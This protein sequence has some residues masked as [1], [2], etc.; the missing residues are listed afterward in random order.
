MAKDNKKA[1]E[2][3]EKKE[4]KTAQ[5][6]NPVI[7]ETN[8]EEQIKSANKMEDDIV[9]AAEEQIQKEKDDKKKRQM[10]EAILEAEY[11]N[12]RE[13]LELRKRRKESTATKEALTASKEALDELKGGKLTPREYEKKMIEVAKTKHEAFNKIDTDHS[14][15]LQE[16]KS[17]FPSY[18]CLEWEYERWTEGYRHNHYDW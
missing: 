11:I 10:K 1:A 13:L 9:K 14:E 15:L 6:T 12:K 8:I 17:N 5:V 2:A 16:L 18:N 4:Q 7:D 3:A